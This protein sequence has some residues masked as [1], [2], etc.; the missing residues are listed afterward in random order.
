MKE[1]A[2]LYMLMHISGI[3]VFQKSLTYCTILTSKPKYKGAT[4]SVGEV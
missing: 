1:E 4:L 2:D 3:L